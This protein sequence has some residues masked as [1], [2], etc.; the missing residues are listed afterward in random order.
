MYIRGTLKDLKIAMTRI[1]RKYAKDQ[2]KIIHDKNIWSLKWDL[3]FFKEK[4]R[5][6]LQ[7]NIMWEYICKSARKKVAILEGKKWAGIMRM[8]LLFIL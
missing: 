3:T 4:K 6:I 7:V 5:D 1:T 8:C 2:G